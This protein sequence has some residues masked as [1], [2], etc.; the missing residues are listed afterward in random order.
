MAT[1]KKSTETKAPKRNEDKVSN[2][3]TAPITEETKLSEE[4]EPV[5]T[6]EVQFIAKEEFSSQKLHMIADRLFRYDC[7]NIKNIKRDFFLSDAAKAFGLRK[8][9]LVILVDSDETKNLVV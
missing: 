2:V 1:A 8:G 9:D 7:L 5:K 6:E 4:I 3:E